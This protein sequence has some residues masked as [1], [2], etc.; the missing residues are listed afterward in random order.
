MTSVVAR[1]RPKNRQ[2]QITAKATKLFRSH[3]YPHV[4]MAA[5]AEAEGITASALYRHFRNKSALLAAVF[6]ETFGF[7]DDVPPHSEWDTFVDFA[8]SFAQEHPAVGAL[9]FREI[10]YL[11]EGARAEVRAGLR[12]WAMGLRPLVA[13]LR[14]ETDP[15]QQELLVWAIV[16]IIASPYSRFTTVTG[17]ARTD[18][19]AAALGAVI[20]TP[21]IPTGAV[22]D[23]A[24][25]RL[26][27]ARGERLLQA[28]IDQFGRHGY[29]DASMADIGRTAEITGTNIYSSYT[30]KADLYRT[31]LERGRHVAQFQLTRVL[32]ESTTARQAL[33][34][35]IGVQQALPA[36]W[37]RW[38][39]EPEFHD[40]ELQSIRESHRDYA[41]EWIALLQ[42]YNPGLTEDAA[43]VRAGIAATILSDLG[44]TAS[45]ARR[46]SFVDNVQA[47]ARAVV[48]GG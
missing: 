22:V 40:E 14:P 43:R 44:Q 42:E 5:I 45:L 2:Q 3:G 25:T 30:G 34:R 46:S 47:L 6:E 12:I 8:V 41:H 48:L 37:T 24:P 23:H 17:A 10:R 13:R 29:A 20:R 16:S 35:L 38:V 9:W 36:L 4:S 18:G 31:A 27:T 19:M 32:A 33:I 15:G 7:L 39:I 21:L 26:P 11:P 28:A 1:R